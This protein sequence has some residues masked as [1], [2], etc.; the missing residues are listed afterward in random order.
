MN[1][2]VAGFIICRYLVLKQIP[3]PSLSKDRVDDER[4]HK[5]SSNTVEV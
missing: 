1:L 4:Q 2:Q 3:I 5:V